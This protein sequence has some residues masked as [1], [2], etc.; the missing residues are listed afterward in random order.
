M[1]RRSF[2]KNATILSGGIALSPL[3]LLS[4]K[5][6]G[7]TKFI[8]NYDTES[9]NCLSHLETIV[10]MHIE[11]KMPATFFIVSNIINN[12]NKHWL[13]N[14]L[15]NPLF[16]IA[17][18]STSHSLI[19]P[20]PLNPNTGNARVEI[21]DSKKRL[22]DLFG[23][24]LY[25]YATPYGYDEGF[26]GHKTVLELVKEAGYKYITT[27]LWG[28]GYS[29]PAPILDPYSYK[30]D[31]YGEI[32]EM[33]RHG[34]HENVLKGHSSTD[35]IALLQWPSPWPEGAIPKSTIHSPEEE[36]EVNKVFMNLAQNENKVYYGP[37]WHP[38]SLGRFDPEMK[39]LNYTFIYALERGFAPSTFFDLY[40]AISH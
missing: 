30:G 37:I 28:T 38:W 9:E 3:N 14:I 7:Q 17:S 25:G 27:S 5:I 23:K 11:H 12:S 26:K 10:E 36:F 33:P 1:K 34:W 22:E 21:L 31:G 2:L 29:L 24:E 8:A 15:D 13:V 35:G 40:Q 4:K 19:L 39:M 32:W 20:H 6:P 16:E 18:H